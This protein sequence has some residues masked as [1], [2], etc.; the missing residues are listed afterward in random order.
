MI[1]FARVMEYVNEG[2]D[3]VDWRPFICDCVVGAVP[4]IAI[5]LQLFPIN[6]SGGG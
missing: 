5:A 4:W 6:L 2:R 1:L 3:T